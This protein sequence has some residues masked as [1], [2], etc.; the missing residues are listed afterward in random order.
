MAKPLAAPW[1]WQIQ[2]SPFCGLHPG[3][4]SLFSVPPG[5][6]MPGLV[7]HKCE[8]LMLFWVFSPGQV[9]TIPGKKGKNSPGSFFASASE[10]KLT[11]SKGELSLAVHL[12]TTQSV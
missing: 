2:K 1:R 8:L 3:S 6:E 7:G 10:E 11:K 5:W 9:Q 12:Q 4:L